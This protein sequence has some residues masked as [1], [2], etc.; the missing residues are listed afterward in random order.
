MNSLAAMSLDLTD[1]TGSGAD[2]VRVSVT[3]RRRPRHDPLGDGRRPAALRRLPDL[4]RVVPARQRD[5]AGRAVAARA[6]HGVR[7][8]SGRAPRLRAGRLPALRGSAVHARL[9]DHGDEQ[10]ADGIV[11]ID[12][13]LCIGCAYCAV[14]CPYQAR[15]KTQRP[16]YA[17]GAAMAERDEAA[18]RRAA[19][20][21]HQVHV[22][23]RSHRRRPR[24]RAAARRRSRGDARVRQRLHHQGAAPSATSTTRRATCRSS[25]SGR[26]TSGCTRS[27][28]PGRGST[29]CGTSVSVATPAPSRMPCR[30]PTAPQRHA[31]RCELRTESLA[32]D[33]LGRARRRQLHVRRRRRRADRVRRAVRRER[34]RVGRAAARRPRAGRSRASSACSWKSAGRC[35]RQR[36]VQS[37]HVVDV[38]RGDHRRAAVRRRA[39]R[40]RRRRAAAVGGRG[41]GAGLRLLPGAH[42]AG[43]QG[44]SGVARAAAGPADRRHRAGRRRR[45]RSC[46]R[47]RSPAS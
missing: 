38:A 9:P 14:A 36:A 27:S 4:H 30:R 7:R 25:S 17:Y 15:Y 11:T 44:H 18:R 6:R 8:V 26:S 1:A 10:R 5:A 41:A 43:G 33:E 19:R 16:R 22:L 45:A 29:T 32:P 3:T 23:R 40:R 37:A 39:R 24:Q 28:A 47:C 20:R 34:A 31:A 2:V 13:D 35:A 21:R 46:S 42:A 12:Y